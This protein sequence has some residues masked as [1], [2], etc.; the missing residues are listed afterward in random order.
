MVEGG[1]VGQLTFTANLFA[2]SFPFDS[3][4]ASGDRADPDMRITRWNSSPEKWIK[5]SGVLLHI[6]IWI[7][8]ICMHISVRF[9]I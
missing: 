9:N 8:I 6:I 1:S 4:D 5:K 7:I 2:S 3:P